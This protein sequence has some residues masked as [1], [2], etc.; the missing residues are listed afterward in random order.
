MCGLYAARVLA[1]QGVPVTVFEKGPAPGGLAAGREFN[2]NFYDLGAHHLH[3][4]DREI[5]EDMKALMGDRLR[6]AALRAFIRFGN[7]RRRYPLEFLDLLKSVPLG[8]LAALLGGLIAQTVRNKFARE[9]ARNAE[10]A[11]IRLYGRPLYEHFFC[12]FTQAYWGIPP[13]DLSATFVRTRMPRLGA[14]DVV[15]KAL[16]A[17]GIRAGDDAAASALRHETVWYTPTGS[18]ELPLALAEHIRRHGG[19]VILD[20]TATG[21]ETEDGLV[22]AVQVERNGVTRPFPCAHCIS[23]IPLPEL[24]RSMAPTPPHDILEACDHLRYK[25]IA[26]YGLLVRKS[27]V[28]DV[29]FIYFRDRIF[30]RIAEPKNSGLDVHPPD[31]SVLVV[32]MTCD[33]GDDRWNG[34]TATR[35]RILDDLEAE[36]LIRRDEIAECHLLRSAYGYPVFR[37]GFELHFEKAKNYLAAFRNLSSVGRQGGFGYPTMHIAMRMGADT[38]EKVIEHQRR[39]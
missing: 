33:E 38:A 12:G 37:L 28:F 19:A 7:G 23:T 18:R 4:F 22:T 32:E 34:G 20:S 17:V 16:D 11:L 15:K 5:F 30:H 27:R 26:V 29:P 24:I 31:H 25:P 13:S 14:V 21:I 10:D 2:G 35:Q 1:E 3:A 6:P 8:T 36:G 9:P 39:V